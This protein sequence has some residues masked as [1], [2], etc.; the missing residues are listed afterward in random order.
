[1][2]GI[3]ADDLT[4]AVDV[5][6]AL[7]RSGMSTALTFG[8][9]SGS[10]LREFGEFDAVVAALKVRSEPVSE[11]LAAVRRTIEAFQ[12][13]GVEF[14]YFKYCSTFDSTPAGNI[15]P[16]SDELLD[17]RKSKTFV[18]VPGYPDNGRTVYQGHL[19][20][21]GVPLDESPM[22]E[23]PLNPMTDS[24]VRRLLAPQTSRRIGSLRYED[25]RSG[26]ESV[27]S[28]IAA[29][30]SGDEPLHVVCDTITNDDLTSVAAAV[31]RS[32]V[33]GGA[34][35]M[36]A[37]ICIR[38]TA[39]RATERAS[40]GATDLT[41]GA[42]PGPDVVIAGSASAATA[43]QIAAFPG[44]VLRLSAAELA[45]EDT[46]ARVL[47][48][49]GLHWDSSPVL[50]ASKPRRR[51]TGSRT[52]KECGRAAAE[53]VETGLGKIACHLA[54]GG[55]RRLIVAGG[56]TSGAVAAALGVQ[57]VMVGSEICTGI[58]WALAPSSGLALA[59]KSGNFGPDDFFVKAFE[60]VEGLGYGEVR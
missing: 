42:P 46:P 4:G 3:I 45:D 38:R 19:F 6:A 60:S 25:L 27:R 47:S 2:L 37:E 15:G 28:A 41:P 53:A 21:D 51:D 58:P 34:A 13:Q 55:A 12:Q 33:V 40:R 18:H 44:P 59:F 48:W 36:A 14:A 31:E 56:E 29:L 57:S 7:I 50:V 22:R 17:L 43:R 16:I 52:A 32:M 26:A 23:H 35:P 11:A 9:P 8:V 39:K 30:A 24:D 5:A 10:G 20:V 54:R 1:M 49:A